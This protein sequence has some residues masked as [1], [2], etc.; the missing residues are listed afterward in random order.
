MACRQLSIGKLISY[1]SFPRSLYGLV[2][3]NYR[4]FIDFNHPRGALLGLMVNMQVIGGA[5]S[6]PFA[7]YTADKYSRWH[8]IFR[9]SI[10][11]ILG[12]LLQGYA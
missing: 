8:P 1:D 3:A 12:G 5:V 2:R 10:I 9:G 6:L 4:H 11:I 7:P